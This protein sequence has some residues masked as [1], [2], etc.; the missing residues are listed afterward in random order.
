MSI[1][2]LCISQ[3]RNIRQAELELRR[4]N[5][6]C[7]PNGSGKTSVLEAVFV[8]GSGRSFRAT[9]LDPVIHH[10]ARQCTV[11]ASLLGEEEGAGPVAIGVSRDRDGSF[12]G[13]IQGQAIRN[14]AELARRLPLQLINSDT[15][16]LLE[17]GPKV[18]RQFLDWGVFHVEHGFH[19]VWLDVHRCLRQRNALLRHDRISMSQLEIW[20]SRLAES[21]TQLDELR[22]RYFD[23][24]YPIFQQTLRELVNLDGLE[25]GYLRGWDRERTLEAVLTEQIEK[26]RVRGFTQSGPHRADIRVRIRGLNAAEVLSRG[27]QKLV[28]AA[29]KLAQGRLFSATQGRDCVFLVDDLPAELDREHRRQLCQLLAAMRCQVLLSCVDATELSGCWDGLAVNEMKLFHVEHGALSAM[30]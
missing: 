27:Q 26:D 20:N 5:L 4:V 12:V 22:L 7:G 13:R 6:L 8:L 18:R 23:A 11:F 10:E 21:A 29:M 17:G 2:R 28:V 30:K 16:A 14:S 15:F 24:F 9:R 3:L 19:R 25:L 1:R